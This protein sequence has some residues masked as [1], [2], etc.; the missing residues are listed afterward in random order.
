M[1]SAMGTAAGGGAGQQN[2]VAPAASDSP[3]S[4]DSAEGDPAP[5]AGTSPGRGEDGTKGTTAS[6]AEPRNLPCEV[7][8][9]LD[10]HC[11]E[12]HD[13]T[14]L[15]AP[16][17]LLTRADLMAAAPSDPT[18]TLADM[19]LERMGHTERP[20]PPGQVL[21]GEVRAPFVSWVEAGMAADSCDTPDDVTPF[22]PTSAEAALKK[23]KMLLTGDAPTADELERYQADPEAL[24]DLIDGFMTHPMFEQ[25]LLSFFQVAFQQKE[26]LPVSLADQIGDKR[27]FGE[28]D[29]VALLLDNLEQSFPR[30]A[31][32]IVREG[33]PFTDVLT[34]QR[35]ELTTAMV[36]L[37]LMID[38][39]HIDDA[40]SITERGS[41]FD[42]RTEGAAIAFEESIDPGS[43]NFM[44]FTSI[45][46]TNGCAST[47]R[48]SKQD[49]ALF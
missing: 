25:K 30:T 12:C 9:F 48:T 32:R 40:L 1:N 46:A 29:A 15:R 10:A 5:S 31:L 11:A 22:E 45:G 20:M 19:A 38:G 26:L 21:A 28:A 27:L 35:F 6:P 42:V 2:G 23:V 37:L 17:P 34:T 7:A 44:H 4:A 41:G 18:R 36:S 13:N 16:R 47:V 14:G 8:E 33:Q 39:R 49:V 43:E 24:P 3:D